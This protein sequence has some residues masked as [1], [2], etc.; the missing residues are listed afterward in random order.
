MDDQFALAAQLYLQGDYQATG[1]LLFE[2]L[3]G[4]TELEADLLRA[5]D[6]AFFWIYLA[7]WAA[8]MGVAM[9]CG[10]TL[11]ILMVRRKLYREAVTTRHSGGG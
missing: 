11:W 6:R 3:D 9:V 1:D 2:L 5:R 10:V 7:E 8:V 4:F